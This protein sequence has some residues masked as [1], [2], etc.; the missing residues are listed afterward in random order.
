MLAQAYKPELLGKSEDDN[1][2]LEMIGNYCKQLSEALTAHAY[3][4]QSEQSLDDMIAEKLTPITSFLKGQDSNYIL[5]ES[6]S[7]LDF[8]LYEIVEVLDF[9]TNRQIYTTYPELTQHSTNMGYALTGF[10]D[11]NHDSINYPLFH[12]FVQTNNWP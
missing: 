7:Y 6:L 1:I 4:K 5:G 11:A 10:Y 2:Q 12:R 9:L 3:G 8:Y